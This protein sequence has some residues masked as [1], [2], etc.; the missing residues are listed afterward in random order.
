MLQIHLKLTYIVRFCLC[1]Y[2][3]M[4]IWPVIL[5]KP[6]LQGVVLYDHDD[7]RSWIAFQPCDDKV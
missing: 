1:E 7:S 5:K 2:M 6:A 4:N 3:S